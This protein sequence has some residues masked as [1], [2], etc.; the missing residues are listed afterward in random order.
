MPV[1]HHHRTGSREG[2]IPGQEAASSALEA[3]AAAVED[4][5]EI[6]LLEIYQKTQRHLATNPPVIL[7]LE[8]PLSVQDLRQSTSTV[9]ISPQRVVTSTPSL[10]PSAFEKRLPKFLCCGCACCIFVFLLIVVLARVASGVDELEQYM[11]IA[12]APPPSPPSRLL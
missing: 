3:G 2:L 10:D 4:A 5:D 1:P 12:H 6:E 9:T 7:S 11:P 8:D